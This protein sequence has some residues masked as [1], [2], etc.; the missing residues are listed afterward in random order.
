MFIARGCPKGARN[1]KWQETGGTYFTT[2]P[3]WVTVLGAILRIPCSPPYTVDCAVERT[4]DRLDDFESRLS[5]L[6]ERVDEVKARTEPR[7]FECGSTKH[8]AQDCPQKAAKESK[9][10]KEEKAR[11]EREEASGE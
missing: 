5:G 1:P 9:R 8:K 10:K 6:S 2:V 7:C 11:K 3:I 4:A